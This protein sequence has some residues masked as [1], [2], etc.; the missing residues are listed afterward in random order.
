[1]ALMGRERR[2]KLYF[3]QKRQATF[4]NKAIAC[5]RTM[6]RKKEWLKHVELNYLPR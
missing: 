2:L 6:Q 4:I 3:P 5:D 1:M